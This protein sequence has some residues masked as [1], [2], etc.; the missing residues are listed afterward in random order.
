MIYVHIPLGETRQIRLCPFYR[1]R[2]GSE[3]LE[4]LSQ[5]SWNHV[6][7]SGRQWVWGNRLCN[8]HAPQSCRTKNINVYFS[9][10][11]KTKWR[12]RL[13][14]GSALGRV[15]GPQATISNTW[16]PGLDWTLAVPARKGKWSKIHVQ[17][18]SQEW[19]GNCMFARVHWQEL[20]HVTYQ[21]LDWEVHPGLGARKQEE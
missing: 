12:L 8:K 10:L 16:P 11:W 3:E 9:L 15:E 21:L 7:E 14:D 13:T 1:W 5:A 4:W 2:T 20:S 19:G 6:L 18:S 17:V